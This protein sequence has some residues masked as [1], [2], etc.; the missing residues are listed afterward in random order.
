MTKEKYV[1]W[2]SH[3]AE[4]SGRKFDPATVGNGPFRILQ[5]RGTGARITD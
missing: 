5:I 3:L 1:T 4:E 2:L